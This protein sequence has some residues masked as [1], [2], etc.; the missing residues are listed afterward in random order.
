VTLYEPGIGECKTPP[1][2]V[3]TML[4]VASGTSQP[5][6]DYVV[7]PNSLP[8]EPYPIE[9]IDCTFLEQPASVGRKVTIN[10]NPTCPCEL[11]LQTEETTW[12]RVKALY[13]E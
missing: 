9:Y 2:L 10:P 11:P 7:V 3:C 13:R 8:N 1:V 12:G 5:C 4:F 6:C